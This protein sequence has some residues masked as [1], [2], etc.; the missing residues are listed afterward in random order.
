MS[1]LREAARDVGGGAPHPAAG[2]GSAL[3]LMPSDRMGGAERMVHMMAREAALS[4]RFARVEVFVLCWSRT[5]TL[6]DL[7]ALGNVTLHYTLAANEGGGLLPLL[8]CLVRKRY[9][10]VFS[11]STHLNA[12]CSLMRR[13]GALR[14][15]RLVAR[16]STTIF[17]RNFGRRGALIRMLYKLYGA[18]DLIVCQTERMRASLD[19]HTQGRFREKLATLPNPIDMERIEAGR[20]MAPPDAIGTMPADRIKI[21]WCGRLEPV[22]SPE[23]AIAT[24]QALHA[25]GETGMHLVMIGE[26]SLREA[27]EA[28]ARALGIAGHVT[29]AGF[30]PLPSAILAQCELGLLTSDREGFPNVILEMLA[31]GIKRVVTTDCAGELDAIPGLAVVPLT[32]ALTDAL[33]DALCEA[34]DCEREPDIIPFL[35]RRGVASYLVAMIERGGG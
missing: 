19:F 35:G 16:E 32:G 6:D 20:R 12:L 5:G 4:G 14:V 8:W 1:G 26:G 30:H 15:V 28:Q 9:A 7:E 10:F 13:L 3:F 24:L 11:S 33:A 17:D 31:S 25:A 23:R 18:Q 34:R 21:A 22:K 29:F 27:L 2:T